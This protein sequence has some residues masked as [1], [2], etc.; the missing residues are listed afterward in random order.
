[1]QA[2]IFKFP[3]NTRHIILTLLKQAEKYESENP[4]LSINIYREVII[5]MSHDAVK[6][7]TTLKSLI[8]TIFKIQKYQE[9]DLSQNSE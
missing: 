5:L 8:R 2:T 4:R 3:T 1:M 9:N 6:M 7:Q